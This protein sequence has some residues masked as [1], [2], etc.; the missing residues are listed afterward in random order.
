MPDIY[1]NI[2]G[3]QNK[4]LESHWN[5]TIAG[6]CKEAMDVENVVDVSGNHY[7]TMRDA[8]QAIP[9]IE[10]VDATKRITYLEKW[11]ISTSVD[12]WE[13]AKNWINQNLIPPCTAQSTTTSN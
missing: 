8:I 10:Q 5:I 7:P 13:N 3:A 9:G 11:N 1:V 4:Y 6:L 12:Q 2:L